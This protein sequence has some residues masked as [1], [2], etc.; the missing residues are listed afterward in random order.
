MHKLLKRQIK[1]HY[2]TGE[3]TEEMQDLL[4]NISAAY[5]EFDRERSFLEHSMEVVSE[6]LNERNTELR[7]ELVNIEDAYKLVKENER[8]IQYQAYHDALT[9]LPNRTLLLDRV[10]HAITR[11]ARSEDFIAILFIDLDHFKKVNDSA[12]HQCGDELLIEVSQRIK[13]C[14]RSH[15]TLSRFGGD[16][17]VVLLENLTSHKIISSICHRILKVLKEPFNLAAKS[18]YIS[19]SIG[20]AI[21]PQD[22]ENPEELI[23]KADLAMYHAKENGR[24]I[25]EF[26]NTAIERL[27]SYQLEIENKL[28]FAIENKELSIHYQPKIK[29]GSPEINSMEALLRWSPKIGKAISPVD[30]IPIAEKSGLIE[31]IDRWVIEQ[32][33][34]QIKQWQNMGIHNIRIAVNLSAQQFSNKSLVSEVKC[35]LLKTGISGQ[36]LEFEITESMLMENLDQVIIILQKLRELGITIAIDDFG[37]GYSSLNYLQRLPIDSIKIDQS[38]IRDY[39]ENTN[40]SKIIDAIISLG[41]SLNLSVVAEGVEELKSARYLQ[42]QQCDYIQGY[43]FYKPMPAQKMTELLLKNSTVKCLT[44]KQ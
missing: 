22:D 17:F 37:T 38:F 6:E 32:A 15:D 23:R 10:K 2:V 4:K 28:H 14:L 1:R 9:D 34:I 11:C 7:A 39:E 24:G 36:C 26:F 5:N 8:L 41:H 40:N 25:F 13:N 16:E 18:F 44:L 33:C 3:I 21:H 35:I 42:E 29:T 31:D 20:V 27:V 12:G 30:F 19:S 43:Y